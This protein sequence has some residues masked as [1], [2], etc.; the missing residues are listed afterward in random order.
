TG[1]FEKR[2]T[3]SWTIKRGGMKVYLS[4]FILCF[5]TFASSCGNDVSKTDKRSVPTEQGNPD[6]SLAIVGAEAPHVAVA[7][8]GSSVDPANPWISSVDPANPWMPK[9]YKPETIPADAPYNEW[10]VPPIVIA[11]AP[12]ISCEGRI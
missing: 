10:D 1:E 3:I 12:K 4:F 6:E 9:I 11:E 2:S 7:P 8:T 5:A